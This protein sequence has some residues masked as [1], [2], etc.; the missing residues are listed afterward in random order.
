MD[1]YMYLAALGDVERASER[2]SAENRV[3]DLRN[4][5]PMKLR[6]ATIDK[7]LDNM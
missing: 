5:F 3:N 7:C 2:A 1:M 4:I 6:Y